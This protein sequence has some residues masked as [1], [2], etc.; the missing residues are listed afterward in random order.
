MQLLA[1]VGI[2]E[3]VRGGFEISPSFDPLWSKLDSMMKNSPLAFFAPVLG[4]GLK[5]GGQPAELDIVGGYRCA[6]SGPDLSRQAG[7][8][9]DV[10]GQLP[11]QVAAGFVGTLAS[12]FGVDSRRPQQSLRRCAAC[13]RSS[14]PVFQPI[15]VLRFRR[16]IC[17][18]CT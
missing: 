12:A 16:S 10:V 4:E 5:T 17:Q 8:G 7:S 6:A 9:I 1:P 18:S 2:A 15:R 13:D 11:A 14:A 3:E